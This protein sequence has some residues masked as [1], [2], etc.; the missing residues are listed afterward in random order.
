MVTTKFINTPVSITAI[1]F[2]RDMCAYPK[3]MEWSG[4]TI[5]F[6][7]RGVRTSIRRGESIISTVTMSDGERTF[8]LR[9]SAGAWTLLGV[10]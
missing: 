9:E 5:R 6:I 8:C 7:E 3:Q 10:V 1:G 4:R 2:G